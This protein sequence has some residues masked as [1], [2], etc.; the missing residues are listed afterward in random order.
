MKLVRLAILAAVICI[1]L[2]LVGKGC[3]M[4]GDGGHDEDVPAVADDVAAPANDTPDEAKMLQEEAGQDAGQPN[5]ELPPIDNEWLA[6]EY[7]QLIRSGEMTFAQVD[8]IGRWVA[9]NSKHQN[10]IK[11]YFVIKGAIEEYAKCRNLLLMILSPDTDFDRLAGEVRRMV[12]SIRNGGEY[13]DLL[14]KLRRKMQRFV[15]RDRKIMSQKEIAEDLYMFAE[16]HPDGIQSFAE[17]K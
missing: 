9:D 13:A 17:L 11:D 3:D 1:V 8:E 10:K 4:A 7:L 2:V 15:I 16:Q 5:E 12:P 6:D 14:V